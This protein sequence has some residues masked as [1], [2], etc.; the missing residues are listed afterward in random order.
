LVG[1]YGFVRKEL[2]NFLRYYYSLCI[3]HDTT[4]LKIINTERPTCYK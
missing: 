1:A 4:F 2:A 3:N